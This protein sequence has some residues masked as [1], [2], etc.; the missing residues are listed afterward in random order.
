[1]SHPRE[2]IVSV[3]SVRAARLLAVAELADTCGIARDAASGAFIATGAGGRIAAIDAFDGGS[4]VLSSSDGEH[5]DN[6]LLA[7]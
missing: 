7:L 5:W 1:M 4:T 6:H 2:G 3:W